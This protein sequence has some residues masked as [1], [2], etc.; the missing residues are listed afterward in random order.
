MRPT[1]NSSA[2]P[3]VASTARSDSP[4]TLSPLSPGLQP[5]A[6]TAALPLVP[7]YGYAMTTQEFNPFIYFIF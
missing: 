3:A 1:G 5:S 6:S 4:P 7:V 2:G